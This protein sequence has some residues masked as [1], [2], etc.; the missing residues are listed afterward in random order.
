M[1]RPVECIETRFWSKL[2]KRGPD[3]CWEWQANRYPAGYGQFWMNG[4][5]H[6]ASRVAYILTHGSIELGKRICHTC[7]NP[8]CCN[9]NHLF[10]GTPRENTRDMIRKGRL[11]RART[12]HGYAHGEQHYRAKLTQEDV[13]QIRGEYQKG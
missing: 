4:R 3:D 2:D 5:N 1:A 13:R 12:R 9:P 8:P 6:Q 10:Q 11:N 7:D